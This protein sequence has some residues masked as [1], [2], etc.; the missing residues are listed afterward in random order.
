VGWYL[1]G[2]LEAAD[3]LT[4]RLGTFG[5]QLCHCVD[6]LQPDDISP[7]AVFRPPMLPIWR[8][9]AEYEVTTGDSAKCV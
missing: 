6:G 4:N 9:G 2:Q 3:P 8:T 5:R 7:A 1:S